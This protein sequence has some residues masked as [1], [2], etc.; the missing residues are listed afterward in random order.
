M[1]PPKYFWDLIK[2]FLTSTEGDTKMPI[3]VLSAM[4]MLQLLIVINIID[5]QQGF[6]ENLAKIYSK[7]TH[8]K[9][10]F[11]VLPYK[12]LLYQKYIQ[13]LLKIYST[14]P[15]LIYNLPTAY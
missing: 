6:T 12:N 14:Y 9:T 7:F 10:I 2:I 15:K 8:N 3:F 5:F 4:F 1:K 11:G 13:C